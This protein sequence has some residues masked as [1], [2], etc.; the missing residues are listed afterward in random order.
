MAVTIKVFANVWCL[1]DNKEQ[2]TILS[3]GMRPLV[4]PEWPQ[5][6]TGFMDSTLLLDLSVALSLDAARQFIILYGGSG[7]PSSF[8]QRMYFRT[9]VGV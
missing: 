7:V 8:T 5:Q 3:F 6:S 9:F 1:M 4:G 2:L